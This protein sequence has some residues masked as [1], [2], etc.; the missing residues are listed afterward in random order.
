LSPIDYRVFIGSNAVQTG[1]DHDPSERPHRLPKSDAV[2][3]W[4][5]PNVTND[6]PHI[7]LTTQSVF[8]PAKPNPSAL[9]AV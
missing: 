5:M 7:E 2:L 6:R 8:L 4:T 1:S 3:L 9:L